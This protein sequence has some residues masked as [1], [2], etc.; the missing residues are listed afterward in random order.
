[1]STKK[2]G[3]HHGSRITH[4]GYYPAFLNLENKRV[5]VVGGG[6]VAERK[7]LALLK[8]GA[9]VTVIS[10]QITKRIT[11]EKLKS[12]IRHV[13]RQ[14]RKGDLE[15]A[16]LT[17]AATDSYQINKKISEEAPCLVNVVDTPPLCNFIVPSVVQ[18]GFLTIAV[19]TSGVSPAISKAIRHELE[20]LYGTEF[21]KYLQFLE[22]I[23]VKAMEKIRDKEK[24]T[25]FLK[26][27]GTANVVE[28]LREKGFNE[29]KRRIT[30]NTEQGAG[31]QET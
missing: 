6:E 19:S 24:R 12:R 17:I 27:F 7:I 15:N 20:K 3:T 16:F 29:V 10:P 11:R 1:M 30:R 26:S 25:K 9:H 5:V 13:A 23:R 21:M 8:V 18:R 31:K 22:K 4:H 28:M 2:G 14:Y